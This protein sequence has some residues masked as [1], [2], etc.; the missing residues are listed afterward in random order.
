MPETTEN[1]YRIPNPSFSGEAFEDKGTRT[2][3][4]SEEKGILAL[5]APLKSS[6]KYK[7]RTFLFKRDKWP[8]MSACDTWVREHKDSFKSIGL[9]MEIVWTGETQFVE[10]EGGSRPTPDELEAINNYALE[11]LAADDVYVR[12]MRI[13]NDQWSRSKTIRLSR[14]FQRSILNS[15]VGKS[16]LMSHPEVKNAIAVPEGRFFEAQDEHLADGV[17]WGKAKFYIVNSEDNVHLRKQID[18]GVYRD[19]SVGMRL[20]Q[21]ICSICGED[22]F[23]RECPH[24]PGQSYPL[25]DVA[26]KD[27]DPALDEKQADHA[28]CGIWFRGQGQALEGSIVYLSELVGTR[29]MA[30]AQLAARQG[31]FAEAKRL[32]I[33]DTTEA[34]AATGPQQSGN[35][36]KPDTEES[37]IMDKE[38]LEALEKAKQGLEETKVTLEA[39]VAE[40]T[41][42]VVELETA[43]KDAEVIGAD[44]KALRG[45]VVADVA[46]LAGL[47]KREAEFEAFKAAFGED[48][49]IMPADKLLEL[50]S[51][52]T[53]AVD[54]SL[55]GGRQSKPIER[56]PATGEP[57]GDN[58]NPGDPQAFEKVPLRHV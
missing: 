34:D 57:P 58:E 48:L 52:W 41:A 54:A 56:D 33:G 7:V 50:Q 13:T 6:G 46:R 42:K 20:D 53:K 49:A 18:G 8:N 11:P 16:L 10:R 27:L 3:A 1:Y 37:D 21:Q 35:T 31:D 39:Q 44:A 30:Q 26:S 22:A 12:T 14:G 51:Q 5:Y 32:W 55:P 45:A 28:I 29:I 38:T 25:D 24:I 19:T 17:T 4:I 15:L 47:A 43:A 2:A 23:S 9:P 36:G 40:L